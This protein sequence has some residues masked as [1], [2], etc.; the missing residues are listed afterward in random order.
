MVTLKAGLNNL[1][2]QKYFTQR[3]DEYPG[4]GII[5]SIGRNFYVGF[6]IKL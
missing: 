5:P 2:D 1:T 4:P 6:S 3:A